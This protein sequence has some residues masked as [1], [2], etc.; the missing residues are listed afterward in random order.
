MWVGLLESSRSYSLIDGLNVLERLY[1]NDNLVVQSF[2][3][4]YHVL[5][6]CCQICEDPKCLFM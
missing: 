2:S 3:F 6:L 5:L 4:Q 1:E